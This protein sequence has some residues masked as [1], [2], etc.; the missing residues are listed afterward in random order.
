M[1]KNAQLREEQGLSMMEASTQVSKI[2][3]TMSEADRKP[4][5]DKTEADKLRYN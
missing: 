3:N 5:Q 2:W 1:A 4:Y